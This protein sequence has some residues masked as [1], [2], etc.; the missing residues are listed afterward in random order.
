MD[1]VK[2]Y[3][4]FIDILGFE[5]L[6]EEIEKSKSIDANFIRKSFLEGINRA[7]EQAQNK[8]YLSM[9]VQSSDQWLIISDSFNNAIL[10][11]LEI[12]SHYTSFEQYREIPL[13]IA[14]SAESIDSQLLSSESFDLICENNA[15]KFIKN[16]FPKY[17]KWL[18]YNN[19]EPPKCSFILLTESI[20]NELEN[21]EKNSCTKVDIN[22]LILYQMD[23]CAFKQKAQILEFMQKIG[24]NENRWL[25]LINSLF[26]PPLIYE[27][28]ISILSK[29]KMAIIIGPSEAGK[30]FT[31]IEILW[32]YFKK[33]YNTII[34]KGSEQSDRKKA[35][36]ELENITQY[37]KPKQIT[38]FE[39]PFGIIEYENRE[40]LELYNKMIINEI[41]QANDSYI[42]ITSREEVFKQYEKMLLSN[43]SLDEYKIYFKLG[44][45]SYDF[46]KRKQILLNYALSMNCKWLDINSLKEMILNILRNEHILST[47][48]R[49][50]EFANDSANSE[51]VLFT[52]INEP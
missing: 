24:Y 19:K 37:L 49:L 27:N 47:P 51:M 26:V 50:R 22:G 12:L 25:S 41:K 15:I 10:C 7:L 4:I 16:T 13:E 48:L 33:G 8:S 29:H 32:Q 46:E 21:I 34:I 43:C 2:K 40:K 17:R 11:I 28:I 6:P 45:Q 5:K 39:D 3:L 31:A 1:Q 14:I 36:E 18:E 44:N 20:Y 9:K 23:I 42:I 38:Y 30:S 52:T 35:R